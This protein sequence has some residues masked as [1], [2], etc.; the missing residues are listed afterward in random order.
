MIF[1]ALETAK[2]KNKNPPLSPLMK[3]GKRGI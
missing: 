2:L 1:T 3:G